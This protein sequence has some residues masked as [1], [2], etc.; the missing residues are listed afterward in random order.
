MLNQII[1]PDYQIDSKSKMTYQQKIEDI[2]KYSEN[3]FCNIIQPTVFVTN[4][5]KDTIDYALPHS[6]FWHI[7]SNNR[8]NRYYI[9]PNELIFNKLVDIIDYLKNKSKKFYLVK[10]VENVGLYY[11]VF[12][13]QIDN[14]QEYRQSK[15]NIIIDETD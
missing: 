5:L 13:Y 10:I 6:L 8:L 14:L 12:L 2:K 15:I 11:K 1:P 7:D 4:Q 3:K 9:Y